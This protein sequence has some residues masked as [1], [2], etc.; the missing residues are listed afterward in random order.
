MNNNSSYGCVNNSC[1][2][3]AYNA[4][5]TLGGMSTLADRLS[6]E[7]ENRGWSQEDLADRCNAIKPGSI[8]QVAIHKI[9]TG[10]SKTT[11]KGEVIA[12]ALGVDIG[13]LLTGQGQRAGDGSTASASEPRIINSLLQ[14]MHPDLVTAPKDMREA[15]EALVLTYQAD[16]KEGERVAKAIKTL[17]KKDT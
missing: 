3:T 16:P 10:K 9:A 14:A 13:W 11:R 7:L 15:I 1:H 5:Y 17:L 2:W 4:G 6:A 12:N 8:T